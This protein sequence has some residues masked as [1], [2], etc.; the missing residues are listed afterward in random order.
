MSAKHALQLCLDALGQQT[1]ARFSL[2]AQGWTT[3]L[4][5]KTTEITFGADEALSLVFMLAPVCSLSDDSRARLMK[6]GLEMALLGLGTGGCVLG[7]D[8]AQDRLVLS[9]SHPASDVDGPGF[10]NRFSRFLEVVLRLKTSL[11]SIASGTNE[12][13]VNEPLLNAVPPH[14]FQ[15]I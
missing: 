15:K 11:A 2:E 1:G 9:V 4:Y 3:L 12:Q 13:P 6:E 10:V 5:D 7:Y 14:L 8:R